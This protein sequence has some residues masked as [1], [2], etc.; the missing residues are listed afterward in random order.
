MRSHTFAASASRICLRISPRF[1]AGTSLMTLYASLVRSNARCSSA[2]VAWTA[3][4]PTHSP[5]DSGS[6]S[7]THR[8]DSREHLARRRA[9]ALE[10]LARTNPFAVV[11]PRKL[12]LRPK[13]QGM[14]NSRGAGGET[15]SK[16]CSSQRGECPPGDHGGRSLTDADVVSSGLGI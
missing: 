4:S 10:D 1:G 14:E 7:I 13:V 8:L 12:A 9:H 2:G 5:S 6:Y 11:H 15:P 3:V 16:W